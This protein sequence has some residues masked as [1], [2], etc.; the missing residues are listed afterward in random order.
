M[1][2]AFAFAL[3]VASLS[4]TGCAGEC[5]STKSP[6]G[7]TLLFHA[8]WVAD[9]CLA[10]KGGPGLLVELSDAACSFG[11]G[12]A[13]EGASGEALS[14]EATF[15]LGRLSAFYAAALTLHL[16]ETNRLALDEPIA[17]RLDSFPE[18]AITVRHA[19]S[20]RSGLRDYTEIGGFDLSAGRTE[21]E[22]LADAVGRGLR[23]DPG[24][25]FANS[26]TDTLAL[27][28]LIEAVAVRD[29]VDVLHRELLDPN[30]LLA[31]GFFG[32]DE[33]PAGLVPGHDRR[34][35]PIASPEGFVSQAVDGMFGTATDVDRIVRILFDDGGLSDELL[36]DVVFPQGEDFG[37]DGFGLG[38]VLE[39]GYIGAGGTGPWGGGG[40]F[41]Y[42]PDSEGVA[43][44]LTNGVGGDPGS[45][46]RVGAEVIDEHFA[47][48]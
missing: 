36:A 17:D 26:A 27:S 14:D 42:A 21:A 2:F 46:A 45:V 35:R 23:F 37:D 7:Q 41:V 6:E 48:R 31:T 9:R 40:G 16:V 15:P 1:R 12:A 4:V 13:G 18:P 33:A 19:L 34:G 3:A 30:G 22:V 10:S 32:V 43:V 28:L 29:Y 11:L 20:H 47:I 25:R 39:D 24:A 8:K 5:A 38:V 44:A